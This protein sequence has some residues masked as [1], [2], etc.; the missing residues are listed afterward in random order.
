MPKDNA[1]LKQ[2]LEKIKK[3]KERLEKAEKEQKK[4]EEQYLLLT[5]DECWTPECS[6]RGDTELIPHLNAREREGRGLVYIKPV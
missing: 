1:K 3:K 4:Q 6:Y 2:L 5:I